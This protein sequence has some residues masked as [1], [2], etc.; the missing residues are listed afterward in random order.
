MTEEKR[1]EIIEYDEWRLRRVLA[2]LIEVAGPAYAL[3][4]AKDIIGQLEEARP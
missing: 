1:T 4:R 2:D 3:Q